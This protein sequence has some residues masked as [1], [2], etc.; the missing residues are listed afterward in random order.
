MLMMEAFRNCH[1][2]FPFQAV[3]PPKFFLYFLSLH[4]SC[5]FEPLETQKA[6]V[7]DVAVILIA[8]HCLSGCNLVIKYNIQSFFNEN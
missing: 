6:G 8:L 5:I 4:S 7:A 2:G 3:S 1:I